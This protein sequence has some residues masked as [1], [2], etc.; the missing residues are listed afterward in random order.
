[1]KGTNKE[2]KEPKSKGKR[3]AFIFLLVLLVSITLSIVGYILVQKADPTQSSE[4]TDTII[5]LPGITEEEMLP[6]SLSG[7]LLYEDGTPVAN[8]LL[9]LRSD[10]KTTYTDENGY[11]FFY[12]IECGDH[13]VY[14]M[15]GGNII[16]Q[17][18]LSID[19]DSLKLVADI[20]S[21]G[22]GFFISVPLD[23]AVI[24][25]IL[26]LDGAD[27]RLDIE[28]VHAITYNM[29]ILTADGVVSM[30]DVEM[31]S[32]NK[33][34]LM[35]D[36]MILISR[37]GV[38]LPTGELIR[39]DGILEDVQGNLLD[40]SIPENIPDDI[41]ITISPDEIIIVTENN[42]VIV[43]GDESKVILPSGIQIFSDG[44][45]VATD[46]TVTNPSDYEGIVEVW[47]SG[48][49]GD[50]TPSTDD[51]TTT[52]D[53]ET[54]TETT[55]DD[56]EVT[57]E[58]PDDDEEEVTEEPI[59]DDEEEV[60]EEPTDDTEDESI[61]SGV[62]GGGSSSGSSSTGSV[63][64]TDTASNMEWTQA[65]QID[66]F[67]GTEKL[68]P[69]AEGA[70]AFKVSNT[71]RYTIDFTMT[72]TEELHDVGAIPLQYYLSGGTNT[73][74]E[75]ISAEDLQ[76][77]LTT[78]AAKTDVEYQLHWRWPYESGDDAYDTALGSAQDLDHIITVVIY[79][80]QQG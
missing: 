9:E 39:K 2:N 62:I 35:G 53:D 21:E 47:D 80:E 44:T 73:S 65:T 22:D 48:D 45:I 51:D 78:L 72:I 4:T 71:T 3:I 68:Y 11:F 5:L 79:A 27:L 31:I 55:G 25:I 20:V 77:T 17:A 26:E 29:E 60:T 76:S 1:M 64:V 8:T 37:E 6:I 43:F 57:E 56:E 75:W 74:V 59:D 13:T 33:N 16:A 14:V 50:L 24:E 70:Y 66:L 67:G 28:N 46:G 63:T 12:N 61:G 34:I 10:P 30:E 58:T 49:D 32:A 19:Q 15:E 36:D 18:A 41:A 23:V 40:L 7:Q 52:G 69:G 38:I 54:T 42:T